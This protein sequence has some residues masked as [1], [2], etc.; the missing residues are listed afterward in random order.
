MWSYEPMQGVIEQR[1]M[2]LRKQVLAQAETSRE[3][4]RC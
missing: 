4:L 1:P 3:V 2:E